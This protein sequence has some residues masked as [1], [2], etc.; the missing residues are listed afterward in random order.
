M[1]EVLEDLGCPHFKPKKSK[2]RHAIRFGVGFELH[3]A[4]TGHRD[5]WTTGQW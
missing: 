3:G 4:V 1:N 2:K 5:P